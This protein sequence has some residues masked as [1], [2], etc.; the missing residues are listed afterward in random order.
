[1]QLESLGYQDVRLLNGGWSIWD[2]AMTLPVLNIISKN[3]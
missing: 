3:S 1:M 2:Q